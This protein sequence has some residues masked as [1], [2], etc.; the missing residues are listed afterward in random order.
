MCEKLK[1]QG[2]VDSLLLLSDS[3]L[4]GELGS[5]RH[6]KIKYMLTMAR[7]KKMK[8]LNLPNQDL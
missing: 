5:R 7:E 3:A 8:Y 2:W 1:W 4:A 6:R